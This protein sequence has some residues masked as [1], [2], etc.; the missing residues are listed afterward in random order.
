MRFFQILAGVTWLLR[1]RKLISY[2][3]L[4]QEFQLD[5]AGLEALRIEL[6]QIERVAV[7]QEGK[8]LAWSGEGSTAHAATQ[9]DIQSIRPLAPADQSDLPPLVEPPTHVPPPSTNSSKGSGS[10]PEVAGIQQVPSAE[11]RQLT[12][13]FC[14]LVGST[15]LSTKLDPED[16]QDIIRAYQEAATRVIHEFD[17]FIAKY[18]GDGILVYFGYPHASER[19]AEAAVKTALGVVQTMPSLNVEFGDG[20]DVEIAVRIGIATGVVVVGEIVGEGHAQERTVVGETPNLAA[21]LQGLASRNGIVIG[22]VTK[23]LAGDLFVYQDMDAHEL[24]GIAGLVKAWGVTGEREAEFESESSRQTSKLPLVGRHEE[25]GLLMRAWEGSREGRGNVVLIQGEA[26]IGKSRLLEALRDQASEGAHTWVAIRSSPYHTASTLYPV[27]EHM[28]RAMRWKPN[29][30]AQVKFE[31]LENM[32]RE[33]HSWPMGESVPLFAAMMSVPL[34]ESGYAPLNMTPQQQREATFDVT[35]AALLELAERQPLLMLWEDLHWADPTTVQMLSL[36]IDQVPTAPILVVG[37][38]RPEFAAPWPA[39]SH[40][41]PIT[42]NRLERAEVEGIVTNIGGG[43]AFPTEV[44]D[45][46]VTKADGVPLYVEELT[47][48]VLHSEIL[49]E[50]E[51]RFVMNGALADMNIPETLQASLMSR[52][53]RMPMVRE[54]AQIGAVLGREFDYSMLASLAP[55]ED[56]DLQNGLGQLVENDL[57]Y[58]RGRGQ[59]AHYVFKHALIQDAAY[60]SLLKRSRQKYHL[61]VAELLKERFPETIEA[62]PDLAAHHYTEAGDTERAITYWH[63]AGQLAAGL[64]A[65]K[66][67]IAHLSK[68]LDLL[69]ALPDDA[70]RSSLELDLL[71]AIGPSFVASKGYAATEVGQTNIRARELCD[72]LDD[73]SRLSPILRGLALFHQ[74]RGETNAAREFAT[75]FFEFSQR[76]QDEGAQMLGRYSLG[77]CLMFCG[78]PRQGREHLAK[79]VEQYDP[80][81]HRSLALV[82]SVD[83]GATAQGFEAL[84]LWLLGYPDQALKKSEAMLSL[85][86]QQG[87]PFSLGFAWVFGS[88]VY[89]FRRE[90]DAVS[91]QAKQA[92]DFALKNGF[93]SFVAWGKPLLGWAQDARGEDPKGSDLIFEGLEDASQTGSQNFRPYFNA[94]RADALIAEGQID[95]ALRIVEDELA[96]DAE[97]R[98]WLP[99]LHR[100]RGELVQH[101][102]TMAPQAESS[103]QL[104]LQISRDQ[105]AKSLELRAATSLARLWHSQGKTTEA[106]D[107]LAPVYGWFTEGF[108]TADLKDAKAL[109]DELS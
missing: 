8:F 72:Q 46:V 25:I 39:R 108:D 51:D 55:H 42:L 109:L 104:A 30:G 66:E 93:P 41:T 94:L 58:Q 79:A 69:P 1:H 48:T 81:K 89:Q 103:L 15:E 99:E 36:L 91:E 96:L 65:H 60:Q 38:Y 43:K 33:Q 68:A 74:V 29:D 27:I 18:M 28:K 37:T 4:R 19:N 5:D 24:K 22:S 57:L 50:A 82:Y 23:D 85:A 26:G 100:L 70:A 20:K 34:T 102:E 83:V 76:E 3:A 2:E 21:R 105:E 80:E 6:I 67:T 32:L 95:T 106:H 44:L 78:E 73:K 12:V 45:H 98:L 107:L 49:H 92:I 31:K 7:D 61:Q 56:L 54:V 35:L 17:G 59:R 47:K 101:A 14:D 62:H 84:C 90:R 71:V 9:D 86:Q 97:E 52:L 53:D 10:A 11:R 63:N 16:L 88:M 87:H 77:N 64:S 13:M 75:E 40:I